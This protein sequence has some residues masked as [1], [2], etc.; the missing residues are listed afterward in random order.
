MVENDTEFGFWDKMKYF[1][2]SDPD[3]FFEKLK[4]EQGI[5]N[6][7]LTYAIVGTFLSVMSYVFLFG[8]RGLEAEIHGGLY[9]E[10]NIFYLAMPLII[11]GIGLIITF[12][13]SGL[14]HALIIAF[15]GEG[16]YSSSY[17]VY[18]YSMI[19]FLILSVVPFVGSLAIIYS[20]FLMI[21]GLSKLHNISKGKAALACL[22]PGVLFIAV[23]FIGSLVMSLFMLS[24]YEF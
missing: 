24:S 16:T 22:L 18:T 5:K 20:I 11:F 6:S 19:P 15:K 3:S 21:I 23:L 14:I 10:F 1:F 4:L 8:M 7:L 17:N 9:S 12:A 2:S 13:Y